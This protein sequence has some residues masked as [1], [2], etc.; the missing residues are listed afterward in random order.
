MTNKYLKY[1]QL[2]QVNTGSVEKGS[3]ED[4]FGRRTQVLPY[5]KKK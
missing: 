1:L 5:N 3:E 2:V 4:G